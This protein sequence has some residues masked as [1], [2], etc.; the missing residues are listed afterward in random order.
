MYGRKTKIVFAAMVFLMAIG[1]PLSLIAG[2]PAFQ[3]LF[4]GEVTGQRATQKL[5]DEAREK[6][7]AHDCAKAGESSGAKKGDGAG[8]TKGDGAKKGDA[9]KDAAASA[10]PKD[11]VKPCKEALRELGSAYMALSAPDEVT[12][13]PPADAQDNQE[14]ARE[15]FDLLYQVDPADD[16][17]AQLLAN[18]HRTA[19]KYVLALPIYRALAKENPEDPDLTFAWADTAQAAQELDEAIKAYQAFVKMAPDDPKVD[20]AKEAV[21]GL[22][23]Q[24]KSGV[25]AGGGGLPGGA[26]NLG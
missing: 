17:S 1:Y 21:K 18:A 5:I 19:G 2:L 24:Q 7:D 8:K 23:E 15:A 26:I 12:G 25:P 11:D 20:Q 13:E 3:G 4:S 9:G 6:I 16:E 22:R 14:K 10:L